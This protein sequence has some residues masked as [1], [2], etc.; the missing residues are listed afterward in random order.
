MDRKTGAVPEAVLAERDRI[1]RRYFDAVRDWALNGAASR[2]VLGER[3]L[4]A[5]LDAPDAAVA[6]AHA[7][8]RLGLQLLREG[9]ADEARAQLAEATRLHPDSWAMWRQ[10]AAR[11]ERGLAAGPEFWARVDALG[12]RP[13]YPPAEIADDTDPATP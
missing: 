13:Y 4:A 12:G 1:K 11:N 6:E 5:R 9:Q 8:F 2:F 10:V 7:R 3:E